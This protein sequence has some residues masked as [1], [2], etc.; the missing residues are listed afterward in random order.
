VEG[1][2]ERNFWVS[3]FDMILSRKN[4]FHK[5]RLARGKD[6]NR[7]IAYQPMGRWGGIRTHRP[8]EK[9]YHIAWL[10]L[11]QGKRTEGGGPGSL[12][13]NVWARGERRQAIE[14]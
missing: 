14:K 8:I 13:S 7:E 1:K 9:T 5:T 10:S 4:L 2:K 11:L 6:I 12:S 3:L